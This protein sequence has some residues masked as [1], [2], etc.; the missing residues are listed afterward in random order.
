M[1]PTGATYDISWYSIDGGGGLSMGGD[2]DLHG[3][4]GQHDAGVMPLTG[5]TFS[6]SGGYLAA[7]GGAICPADFTSGGGGGSDGLVGIDDFLGVLSGWGCMSACT[8][9]V[10]GPTGVPDGLVGIDDFLKVLANWGPCP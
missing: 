5:G 9:D 1:A 6:I 2:F 8:A 4:I 3:V 10:N 7:A